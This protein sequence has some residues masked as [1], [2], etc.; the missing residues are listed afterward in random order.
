MS[1]MQH[2]QLGNRLWIRTMKD[3]TYYTYGVCRGLIIDK[4]YM[5]T[6]NME[7]FQATHLLTHNLRKLKMD[8]L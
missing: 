4:M 8:I 3:E 6:I 5:L 2:R 7:Y 1:S